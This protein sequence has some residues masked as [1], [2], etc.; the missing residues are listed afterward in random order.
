MRE[1]PA[2]HTEQHLEMVEKADKFCDANCVWSDHHPDCVRAE[3]PAPAQPYCY[4][5]TENGEEFFAPPTAYVPEN[6]IA[7]YTT[8]PA[9]VR[10][11]CKTHPEA[12][13]GF[14]RNDSH[15]QGRYVCE[16]EHWEEP[17]PAQ[18]LT[19][20]R[21]ESVRH[22]R[23]VQGYNGNWNYDPYMQGLYNGLEFALSL[24]EVREPQFKD[25]PETWLGDINVKRDK[26]SSEAAHGIKGST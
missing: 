24:L 1:Q 7:L 5:Y 6:A 3:Q 22:M 8:P 17:A 10:P 19:D 2:H 12:P 11:P 20:E 14:L 18:P 15:S 25:A 26:L 9:P 21:I 23:N 16:C 13:H 4:T